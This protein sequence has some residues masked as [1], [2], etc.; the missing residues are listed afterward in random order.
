MGARAGQVSQ[1]TAI[2]PDMEGDAREG[3]R[4]WGLVNAPLDV[5]IC[6]Y[7]LDYCCA[8]GGAEGLTGFGMVLAACADTMLLSTRQRQSMRPHP[9]GIVRGILHGEP[10]PWRGVPLGPSAADIPSASPDPLADVAVDH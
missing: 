4:W 10:H 1:R 3:T 8:Y 9:G 5:R 7:L 6:P 2:Y